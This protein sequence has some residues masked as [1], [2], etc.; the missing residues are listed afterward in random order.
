MLA[1]ESGQEILLT[2]TVGFIRKLPHHLV[3]AFRSTLEE[4]VY[5]D[6]LIHVV[7]VSNPQMYE[8]MHICYETLDHLGVKDKKII[9]LFNKV[10]AV[11]EADDWRDF[12]ADYTIMTSL[13]TGVGVDRCKACIEEILREDKR[14]VE[15]LFTYEEAGLIQEIRRNGELLSEEYRPDGIFVQA[16]VPAEIYGRIMKG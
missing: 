9:T 14:L 1:L 2:D 13:K 12:R 5:A 4:A 16:Y 6:V 15:K 10:D 3:E 7:D 11:A 8:Q